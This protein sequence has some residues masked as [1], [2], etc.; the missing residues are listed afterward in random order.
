MKEIIG[1]VGL[2]LLLFAWT[3]QLTKYRR[4]FFIISGIASLILTAHAFLIK[5]VT[6]VIVNSF[7]AIVSFIESFELGIH[8]RRK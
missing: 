6:F 8:K 1:W 4:K 2:V 3:L 5:D 7:I